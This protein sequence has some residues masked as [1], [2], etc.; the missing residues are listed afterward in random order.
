MSMMSLENLKFPQLQN[1]NNDNSQEFHHLL[2]DLFGTTEDNTLCM[3]HILACI[4]NNK[5]NNVIQNLIDTVPQGQLIFMERSSRSRMMFLH[6]AYQKNGSDNV[7]NKLIDVGGKELILKIDN[8]I[9]TALHLAWYKNCASDNVIFQ[10]FIKECL[11]LINLTKSSIQ[12]SSHHVQ[13][14]ILLFKNI[15]SDTVR[16]EGSSKFQSKIKLIYSQTI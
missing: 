3:L 8:G 6:K 7:I 15:A 10:L 11:S 2:M 5:S 13:E 14:Y 16:T 4:V 9:H 1:D 12:K